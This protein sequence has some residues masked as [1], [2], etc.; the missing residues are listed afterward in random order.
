MISTTKRAAGN[1]VILPVVNRPG[2]LPGAKLPLAA[3][4]TGPRIKPAPPRVAALATT[5]PL[6]LFNK[7]LISTVPPSMVKAPRKALVLVS[8]KV[9]SPSF[10][11]VLA[12][13]GPPL[14]ALLSKMPSL[15]VRT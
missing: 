8:T 11:T 10:V 9:P 13:P 2:L 3:T 5:T 12:T 14:A 7:P 6:T 1:R 4:V 15:I